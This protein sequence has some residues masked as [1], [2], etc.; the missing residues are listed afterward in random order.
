MANTHVTLTLICR[1][2]TCYNAFF[3]SRAIYLKANERTPT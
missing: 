1:D 3:N 2:S